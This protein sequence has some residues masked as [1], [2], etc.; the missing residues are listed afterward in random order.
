MTES[1]EM[2]KTSPL[3]QAHI[4]NDV[5]VLYRARMRERSQRRNT[6]NYTQIR[7]GPE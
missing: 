5:K 1:F 2:P 3:V 4:R 7:M 6:I